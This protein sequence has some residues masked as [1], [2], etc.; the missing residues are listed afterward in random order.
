MCGSNPTG[1]LCCPPVPLDVSGV[2]SPSRTRLNAKMPS[3]LFVLLLFPQALRIDCAARLQLLLGFRS[4]NH[5]KCEME[6]QWRQRVEMWYKIQERMIYMYRPNLH[7]LLGVLSY[8]LFFFACWFRYKITYLFVRK[9][10]QK[11]GA[12]TR[13]CSFC[14]CDISSRLILY[15]VPS[16]CLH[17]T[18][19]ALLRRIPCQVFYFRTIFAQS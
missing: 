4:W 10:I 16:D 1:K 9:A 13:H 11:T 17:H 8:L 6:L 5:W 15:F 3:V 18:L 12:H 14:Q 2:F 7:H 19:D